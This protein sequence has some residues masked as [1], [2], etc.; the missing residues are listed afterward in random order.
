MHRLRKKDLLRSMVYLRALFR[1]LDLDVSP[2]SDEA[3]TEVILAVCPLVDDSWPSDTQLGA[4]LQRL[5][6]TSSSSM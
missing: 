1:L 6:Q 2:Y 3:I 4:V 5:K